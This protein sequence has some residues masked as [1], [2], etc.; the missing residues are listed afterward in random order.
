M[1]ATPAH[2]RD[3]DQT[4]AVATR[5]VLARVPTEATESRRAGS[6][7]PRRNEPSIASYAAPT[8]RA[9][10]DRLRVQRPL[11][12][13]LPRRRRKRRAATTAA[14]APTACRHALETLRAMRRMCTE[15]ITPSRKRSPETL[16]TTLRPVTPRPAT[17]RMCTVAI[18]PPRK[19]SPRNLGL[20]ASHVEGWIQQR[21]ARS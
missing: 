11:L 2:R 16:P 3:E 15:S 4:R 9:S 10:I 21:M 20:L 18:T 1:A 7:R 8:R 17:T 14:P 6:R 5:E 12:A 13:R 19:R